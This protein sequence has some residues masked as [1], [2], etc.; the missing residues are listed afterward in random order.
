MSDTRL[1]RAVTIEISF[2]T[3]WYKSVTV[4]FDCRC[5]LLGGISQATASCDDTVL[6]KAQYVGM[7]RDGGARLEPRF[8]ILTCIARYGRYI[9]VCQVIATRTARYRAVPPATRQFRQK[10]IVDGRFRLS[11][12]D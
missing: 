1:Y 5:L 6:S 10:S 11:T 12:A 7:V 8:A 9:P 4:D 3:A 2:V